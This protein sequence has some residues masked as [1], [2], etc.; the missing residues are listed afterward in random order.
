MSAISSHAPLPP[1]TG[2]IRVVFSLDG[3]QVAEVSPDNQAPPEVITIP[4]NLGRTLEI[5]ISQV[6]WASGAY[7]IEG[8]FSSQSV[9]SVSSRHILELGKAYA[10]FGSGARQVAFHDFFPGEEVPIQVEIS[11][12]VSTANVEISLANLASGAQPA[13]V[14]LS[15]PLTFDGK[16]S[17]GSSHWRAPTIRG[18]MGASLLVSAGG[19]GVYSRGTKFAIAQPLNLA[20]VHENNFGI[21]LSMAGQPMLQD[22]FADLWGAKWSRIY[23]RW[24][25]VESQQGHYN[26]NW[27][28]DIISNYQ[29]HG[30]YILGVMGEIPPKWVTQPAVQVPPAYAHF[31]AAALQH[32]QGKIRYWDVFN[33]PDSKYYGNIG[34][35]RKSDPNQDI[36]MLRNEMQQMEKTDPT[37]FRVCCSTGGTEWLRYDKRL[38]DSGLI[39]LISM[40]SMHPYQAGPP[41]YADN[42]LSYVQMARTLAALAASYGTPK[43]VWTTEANWLIGPAGAPGVHA[44]EVSEHEQSQYLVRAN[45]L[46][47]GIHVP[48][49]SHAPFLTGAHRD[50]LVDSLASYSTMTSL[51]SDVQS[52]SLLSLPTGLY[53]VSAMQQS[54]RIL[55]LWTA[56]ANPVSVHVSGMS[57]SSVRDMYGN[58]LPVGNDLR[59]TG[60]PTYIIG[61]GSPTVE[62]DRAFKPSPRPLPPVS[63][64][65]LNPRSTTG[66]GANGFHIT[67]AVGRYDT[68]LTSPSFSV[69]PNA[70][71]IIQPDLVVHKGGVGIVVRD[72]D[73]RKNIRSQF[74]NSVTGNDHYAPEIRVLTGNASR[75]TLLFQDANDPDQGV[76]D[77]E[78]RDV[79]VGPCP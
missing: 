69:S 26:W 76:S 22:E 31:I 18:P 9:S 13:P 79:Q 23:I 60:S 73:T 64:W 33:E 70:C 32:F 16:N 51:F 42:G 21:H 45:L 14:S 50:V 68:Q 74:M 67:S 63:Q 5:R 39:N 25:V 3:R 41:E 34:F 35:D 75:L 53:G 78:V 10:N 61:T 77:F 29:N 62:P 65:N 58:G 2:N 24:D 71:Y 66:A 47:L 43:P 54:G 4:V 37:L 8:A 59:L 7:L 6:T 15:I 48:Y 55:A 1:D 20:A 27:I 17:V 19:K 56:S 30:F 44:P 38:F 52:A 72:P 28:D 11:G 12:Q 40:L 46:S 36:E 49:F 57:I